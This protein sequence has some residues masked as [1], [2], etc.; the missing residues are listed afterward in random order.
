M[1]D[2]R[3]NKMNDIYGL[4]KDLNRDYKLGLSINEEKN[5]Y[6]RRRIEIHHNG[7]VIGDTWMAMSPTEAMKALWLS[8]DIIK[9]LRS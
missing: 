1:K 6:G 9:I 7:H 8:R 3:K 2:D 4:V 5:E